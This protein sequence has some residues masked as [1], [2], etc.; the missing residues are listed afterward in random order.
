MCKL[1]KGP[2][3]ETISEF[4]LCT[5]MQTDHICFQKSRS[6]CQS[7]VD[8]GNAKITWNGQCLQNVRL[9][10]LQKKMKD[11]TFFSLSIT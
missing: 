11:D 10:T 2:S 7:L 1:Y 8:Y 6:L 9:D 4:P 3:D 5:Y